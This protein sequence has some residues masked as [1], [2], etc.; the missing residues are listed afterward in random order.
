MREDVRKPII[1][2]G[3]KM[4]FVSPS[5][6]A[7]EDLKFCQVPFDFWQILVTS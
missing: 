4:I 5:S 7:V 6:I 1:S 3:K 2:K